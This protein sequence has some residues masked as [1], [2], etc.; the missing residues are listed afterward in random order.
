VKN[1]KERRVL[2]D[3]LLKLLLARIEVALWCEDKLPDVRDYGWCLFA[4]SLA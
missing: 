3:G 2:F 1:L 4:Y